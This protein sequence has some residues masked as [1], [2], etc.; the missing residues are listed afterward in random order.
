MASVKQALREIRERW[1]RAIRP[2][3]Y[4]MMVRCL[5]PLR[6][7]ATVVIVNWDSLEFLKVGV[8]QVRRFSPQGTKI[9]VVDNGSVDGSVEWLRR[10]AD[11]FTIALGGNW[12]HGSAL[13]IG[14]LRSRTRFVIALD[15][16]AF[17]ITDSWLDSVLVPLDQ[18]FT[19]AGAHGGEALDRL[20]PGIDPDH[21]RPS[22]VH[23]CFLG[24]KLRRFVYRRRSFKRWPPTGP[25][26]LDAGARLSVCE[27][28]HLYYVEPTSTIGPG[29]LGTVFG[30]V[31][32]HNFHSTLHR[33]EG[34]EGT[35]EG[36]REA[37]ARRAWQ[38]ALHSYV[39]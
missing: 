7:A 5:F 14:F 34:L 10:Q 9:I 16:D 38:Q 35:V 37:D 6:R 31:V 23:P 1:L 27:A 32:Y 30:D 12:G 22:F 25:R 17:P 26:V 21:I 4:L 36:V 28:A 18:G 2:Q 11:V 8:P 20:V 24:M 3:G 19:V 39:E 15:V 29:F 13:D 33:Q